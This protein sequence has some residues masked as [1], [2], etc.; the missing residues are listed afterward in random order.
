M[1]TTFSGVKCGQPIEADWEFERELFNWGV[2]PQHEAVV[3]D[4]VNKHL[5]ESHSEH[6]DIVIM[7]DSEFPA[8]ED[9]V[10]EK[11]NPELSNDES[12]GNYIHI[13]VNPETGLLWI[14]ALRPDLLEY[15]EPVEN[16]W[17][18]EEEERNYPRGMT[19]TEW[20]NARNGEE[21]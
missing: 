15:E 14:T 16:D 17:E 3:M 4:F 9:V 21:G 7:V 19:K 10:W 11:T 12:L 13:W 18:P 2:M 6:S 20:D 1:S 5:V 8:D